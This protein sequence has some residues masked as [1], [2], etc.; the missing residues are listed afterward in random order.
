MMRSCPY[1][2]RTAT[3]L[4][5]LAAAFITM[6]ILLP[7]CRSAA[8]IPS[9]SPKPKI[10]TVMAAASMTEVFSDLAVE[11]EAQNPGINVEFN[12]AGSQQLV[13][14]LASG[15]RADVFASANRKQM[16]AGVEGGRIDRRTVF[17][18]A[19]NKLVIIQPADNPAKIAS[20]GDLAR[21]GVKILLAS[22]EVPVGAYTLEFLEKASQPSALGLDFKEK[23]LANV[24]SYETSVKPV[25][26]KV[27]LGEADAGIV[28]ATDLTPAN[29]DE[30]ASVEI[31]DDL[32][33]IAEYYIAPVADGDQALARMW[34]ELIR[35]RSAEELLQKYGF[36]PVQ[37]P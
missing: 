13:Q 24:V 31:P 30:L 19:R 11:F 3:T 26:V 4:L 15:A 7:S 9:P 22:P 29:R 35:S 2:S 37:D 34:I 36:Q 17:P 32:N 5:S 20:P 25:V 23:V 6:S 33:V 28:Y 16:D 8:E 1:H 27:G 18:F 10:L 21:P 12:F 14:Q